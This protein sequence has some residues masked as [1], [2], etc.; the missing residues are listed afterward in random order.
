MPCVIDHLSGSAFAFLDQSSPCHSSALGWEHFPGKYICTASIVLKLHHQFNLENIFEF[1]RACK[2]DGLSYNIVQDD[3]KTKFKYI[4]STVLKMKIQQQVQGKQKI[5]AVTPSQQHI[6]VQYGF[7]WL[8][9]HLAKGLQKLISQGC[10][11]VIEIDNPYKQCLCESVCVLQ[12][13]H[14]V[15]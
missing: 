6:Q 9:I 11:K 10:G 2:M 13:V 4:V 1:R 12:I 14:F 7:H 8:P 5:S 3:L 15:N